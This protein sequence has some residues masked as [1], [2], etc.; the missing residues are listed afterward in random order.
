M[1]H[2]FSQ[3]IHF[4]LFFHVSLVPEISPEVVVARGITSQRI[5]VEWKVVDNMNNYVR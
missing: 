4:T 5:Y 2:V 3:T 1:E